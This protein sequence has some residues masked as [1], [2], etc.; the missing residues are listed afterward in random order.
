MVMQVFCILCIRRAKAGRINKRA[1]L[2]E[3]QKE[4]SSHAWSYLSFVSVPFSK[5][6]AEIKSSL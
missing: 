3:R 5:T 6:A 4:K 2:F 1:P